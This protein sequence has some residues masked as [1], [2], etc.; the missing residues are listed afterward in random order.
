MLTALSLDIAA[1][2]GL[3]ND[4]HNTQNMC[5]RYILKQIMPMILLAVKSVM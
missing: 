5:I 2:F 1:H 3:S 4:G